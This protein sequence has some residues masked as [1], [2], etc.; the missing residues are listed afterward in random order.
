[1]AVPATF[2]ADLITHVP[3]EGDSFKRFKETVSGNNLSFFGKH[4]VE[5]IP[6]AVGKALRFDGYSTY[7]EGEIAP[8]DP[9][10]GTTFSMW[11]APE[12]YPI[13][14][15]DIATT[16]KITLAGNI[17]KETRNGW[18]F[19]LGKNGNYS[20]DC[21]IGGWAFS[22][23]ATDLLPTYEWSRLV[24]V[25]DPAS[26]KLS[27]YRN[28]ELVGEAKSSGP[29]SNDATTISIGKTRSAVAGD[30][31]LNTFNGLIDEVM[32]YDGIL[33]NEEIA[34][35][36]PE[37]AA[38]LSIPESRFEKDLLR[39]KFHGMPGANWTNESHGMVYSG[40]KYHIFFQKNANGPYMSRLHWGH[41]SS[42]NLYDWT[43]EQIALAPG[44]SYDT[45][46]CWSGCV[47]VDDEITGGKP[48]IIY[49]GVDYERARIIMASPE[50]DDLIYWNKEGIIIDGRP[51]GLSDDFRDPYFFRN[52]NDAY[53]IVGTSKEGVGAVTLHKYN[54]A[55]KTWSND[56]SI[57]FSGNNA[58][59]SG[60]FWEM[61]NITKMENGKWLF[62]VT[63]Q[64][65]SKGVLVLYWTGDISADGKFI[66]DNEQPR[67]LE[68]VNGQ[69]Y[70]LLSPTIYQH[71]GKTIMLG[72]VP[73]KLPTSDNCNLGWAH[74]YSFPREISL[75]ED[76]TLIQKPYSGLSELRNEA[77]FEATGLE[78]N[79][80]QH[81]NG[82]SGR[83]IELEGNFE[84]GSNPFGFKFFQNSKGSAKL[85]YNPAT[86]RLELNVNN[87]NRKKNDGNSFNGV[88][89]CVLPETL[90]AGD[91]LK[92]NVFID[93]SIVDIF[94]NDKY[95]T[96]IRVYPTDSDADGVEVF[97]E[98]GVVKAE[99]MRAWNLGADNSGNGEEPG[100]DP[101][102]EN[103]DAGVDSVIV[104]P[105]DIVNVYNVSGVIVKK[106]VM[107][108]E[109]LN[110]LP[111]GI[112]ILKSSAG[113]KKI[114]K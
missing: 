19:S 34:M 87:I 84:I 64:N 25:N 62:T 40:G 100:I 12:T 114:V 73:D 20:F 32:V 86:N 71:D 35:A 59:E 48:Y 31:Q 51:S 113:S 83:Q 103:P 6:G 11:V 37:N 53:I 66:P 57:F 39:P 28:G 107:A 95:A 49:T 96:S 14:E 2:A 15:H 43:E 41:I 72:I 8:Y 46:G 111:K 23:E 17:N 21:Y 91:I 109:A 18:A 108:A 98:G 78:V 1:M 55:T 65:T 9:T 26:G 97:S 22:V 7:I 94:V 106:S 99:S 61:P 67:E 3:M 30:F 33:S 76:G 42:E 50:D 10:E 27:L 16:E 79:G 36:D 44:E 45:K 24:A 60:T 85:T 82:I 4:S 90:K 110:E 101:D 63:P 54:Q 92:L 70:G 58:N 69:G 89:A 105:F 81:I 52:G 112:Y 74:L 38:D 68:L 29:I 75:A 56:G 5:N 93:G 88:Y 80:N 104:S 77:A 13:V 102:P 47:F